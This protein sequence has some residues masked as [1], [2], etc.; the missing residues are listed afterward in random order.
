MKG[1]SRYK[2]KHSIA[3][4]KKDNGVPRKTRYSLKY[5]KVVNKFK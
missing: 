4:R 3:S 1:D 5:R 2:W